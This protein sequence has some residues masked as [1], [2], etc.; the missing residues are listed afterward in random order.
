MV[1][2]SVVTANELGKLVDKEL[3]IYVVGSLALQET[4]EKAGFKC[5]G[6][7]PEKDYD[8]VNNQKKP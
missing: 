2:A 8:E 7:G 1:T 3:E 6:G 5:F 4:L